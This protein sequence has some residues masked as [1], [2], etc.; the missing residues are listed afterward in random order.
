M[1]EQKWHECRLSEETFHLEHDGSWVPG[2]WYM[3][4]DKYG[5]EEAARMK[6]DAFDHSYPPTK[7]IKQEDVVAFRELTKEEKNRE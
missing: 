7:V 3:W 6:D 4:R 2:R 1:D 5:N